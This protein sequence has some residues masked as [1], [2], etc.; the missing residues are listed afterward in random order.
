MEVLVHVGS[1]PEAQ[2]VLFPPGFLFPFLFGLPSMLPPAFLPFSM[3][4]VS[5]SAGVSGMQSIVLHRL[6]LFA[7]VDSAIQLRPTLQHSSIEPV[8]DLVAVG[9]WA[10]RSGR[11]R[12]AKRLHIL[13]KIDVIWHKFSCMW[14]I[15]K[16]VRSL[17][18]S[19]QSCPGKL[20]PWSGGL[21]AGAMP[22]TPCVMLL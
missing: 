3:T 14:R 15:S 17:S 22:A 10:E 2:C 1:K 19:W 4:C 18:L 16:F 9:W 21:Q 11:H 8:S 13:H 5:E 7:N 20:R 6:D 12:G